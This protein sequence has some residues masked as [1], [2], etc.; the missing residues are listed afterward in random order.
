MTITVTINDATTEADQGAATHVVE[1]ENA[2]RTA[3]ATDEAP[4]VLLPT[5]PA[6]ELKASYE[7]VL[8]ATL[9]RAH[10]SYQK[11][12]AVAQE[13]EQNV[14]E[15]WNNASNAQRQAAVAALTP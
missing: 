13:S 3:A 9:V 1:N 6:A 7:D 11:Q 5:T 2:R 14:R 15:L 12:A 10:A 8:A 4:A